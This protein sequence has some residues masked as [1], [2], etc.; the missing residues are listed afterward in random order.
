MN[1]TLRY[2]PWL[3]VALAGAYLVKEM[4]PPQDP[5]DGFQIHEFSKILVLDR[6]RLKPIDTV[7]RANMMIISAKQTFKDENG[8]QQ[9]AIKWL[10]D[11]MSSGFSSENAAR[12]HK[13]FRI[14]NDEILDLLGLERRPEFYRYSLDEF[15]AKQDKLKQRIQSA[16][17]INDNERNLV[18]QKILDLDAHWNMYLALAKFFSPQP[19]PPPPDDEEWQPILAGLRD[20]ESFVKSAME[21]DA[22]DIGQ[23]FRLALMELKKKNEKIPPVGS[24]LTMLIA[25]ADGKPEEFNREVENYRR[26]LS[27]RFPDDTQSASY[28]VFFNNFAPFYHCG[29][30]YI[31]VFLLGCLAWLG[32]SQPLQRSAL[33]LALLALIIHTSGIGTRMYLQGRP[34]ITNLYSTAPYIGWTGLILALILERI[35]RNGISLVVGAALGASTLFIAHFLALEKGDTLEMMQAVL[36]TN[37][38]L[39][40]HVTIINMGYM[41]TLVAGLIGIIYLLRGI[42]TTSLNSAAIKTMGQMI[43]GVLCFATL[44]SFVGTVL[45]GIW[46]D[47]SWGRFWGWDPKENGALIIVIWNALVLH[48]RWAG[49]V[50]QRGM[51]V[52]AIVGNIVTGWSY[53]GTNQLGVGLHSYGFNKQL[54][55]GLRWFWLS[56]L[57]LIGIGL[58]PT[59]YWLSFRVQNPISKTRERLVKGQT[60]ALSSTTAN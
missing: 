10:L 5:K 44:L 30:F 14:E 41:A 52:L 45:G 53:F 2:L 33:L 22:P 17:K 51:A 9:P 49:L 34:P 57:V 28:E 15:T 42:F 36:D 3:V 25:Y 23:K 60:K 59:K 16:K 56:Q 6:G 48:A 54:A 13:I 40:T 24:W 21:Q 26:Y 12:K 38:W 31:G 18:D 11:V 37:F 55:E 58:I 1:G 4:I 20:W 19:V 35:F 7:A 43:Y 47:Q 8:K 27:E 32:L 29:L 46:G 50:K 39:W